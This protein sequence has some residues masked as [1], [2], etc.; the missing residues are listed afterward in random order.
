MNITCDNDSWM[1]NFTDDSIIYREI[2]TADD[3]KKLKDDITKRHRRHYRLY[4]EIERPLL[5]NSHDSPP[6]TRLH[7]TRPKRSYSKIHV[8]RLQG[9]HPSTLIVC[10][11]SIECPHH[12]DHQAPRRHPKQRGTIC[13]QDIFLQDQC[14]GP[15]AKRL[16]AYT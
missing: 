10:F 5:Q 1:L 2:C 15:Q 12:Q 14:Y 13:T 9:P 11:F 8:Y 3:H 4:A 7:S 6:S 16:L